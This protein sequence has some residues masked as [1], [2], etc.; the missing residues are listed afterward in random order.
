MHLQVQSTFESLSLCP[1]YDFFYLC[2]HVLLDWQNRKCW[3]MACHCKMTSFLSQCSS[4]MRCEDGNTRTSLTNDF[5]YLSKCMS[6]TICQNER[7]YQT[8]YASL[9]KKT[10]TYLNFFLIEP[11]FYNPKIKRGRK[12]DLLPNGMN[13]IHVV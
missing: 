9:R 13:K 8:L 2:E 4:A 6:D 5:S 1:N 12:L 10:P 7:C 3:S 11:F